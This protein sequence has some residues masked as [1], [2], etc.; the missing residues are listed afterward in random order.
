MKTI[1][2][3]A[4]AGTFVLAVILGGCSKDEVDTPF[5]S[6]DN[7]TSKELTELEKAGLISLL[8]KEKFHRDVYAV[9]AERLQ[10]PFFEE[11]SEEDAVLMDLLSIKVDKYGLVN[12]VVGIEA[13]SFSDNA[14]QNDYTDFIQ[15]NTSD[16]LTLVA[17]A[18][19]MERTMIDEI[20]TQQ[21]MLS[22]NTDIV[23][24]Y[25]R[26]LKKSTAQLR[27][28]ADEMEGLRHLYAPQA[29]HQED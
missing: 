1:Q 5:Y 6:A 13:G 14:I 23:V 29:G 3:F 27:L 22:G 26:M 24:A 18:E 4:L 9:I 11:L 12:P 21:S 16:P 7:G 17:Y 25:D 20:E 15:N 28:L 2:I 19:D 10:S 8:E